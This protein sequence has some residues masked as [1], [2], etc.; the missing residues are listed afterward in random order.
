MREMHSKWVRS[1]FAGRTNQNLLCAPNV[2]FVKKAI[3]QKAT[4][5]LNRKQIESQIRLLRNKFWLWKEFES[6]T[7]KRKWTTRDCIQESVEEEQRFLS[8]QMHH[9][10][11][12]EQWN[13]LN[14]MA[15]TLTSATS[16]V[17]LAVWLDYL[18]AAFRCG[19]EEVSIKG[20]ARSCEIIYKNKQSS[21][22]R[23][24]DLVSN[25]KSEHTVNLVAGNS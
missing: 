14:P 19:L 6:L 13:S 12:E 2:F 21:M 20:D 17:L 8:I 5:K 9:A 24:Y 15:R 10:S 18:I 7:D 16:N 4:G 3:L 25:S 23:G 22:I 11:C 1:A